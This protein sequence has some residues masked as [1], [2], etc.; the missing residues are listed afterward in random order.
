[1]S[2]VRPSRYT[3]VPLETTDRRLP[4][5][6]SA[7]QITGFK[8][9]SCLLVVVRIDG[10]WELVRLAGIGIISLDIRLNPVTR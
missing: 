9:G 6:R 8:S 2:M 7:D 1:M 3:E 10:L 5:S 4:L